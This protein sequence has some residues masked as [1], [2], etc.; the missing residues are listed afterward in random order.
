M[1]VA[2]KRTCTLGSFEEVHRNSLFDEAYVR[3]CITNNDRP[4]LSFSTFNEVGLQECRMA[5]GIVGPWGT[6]ESDRGEHA[7]T[8]S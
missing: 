3:Y 8:L 6:L 5:E 7:R 1:V 2:S 4:R